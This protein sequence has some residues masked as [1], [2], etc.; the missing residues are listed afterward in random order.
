MA[1][2]KIM[3]ISRTV[4]LYI[5][6]F[7]IIFFS[8]LNFKFCFTFDSILLIILTHLSQGTR[9]RTTDSHT[10]VS[11]WSTYFTVANKTGLNEAHP[12]KSHH[13]QVDHE[14]DI[15]LWAT[16]FQTVTLFLIWQ[17][18]NIF[19]HWVRQ[20]SVSVRELVTLTHTCT[21]THIRTF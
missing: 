1:D 20:T 6:F 13:F 4:F 12:I 2:F 17:K 15:S 18:G 5:Y 14:A 11:H 21:P 8:L 9:L 10:H 16:S 19:N 7:N 3:I